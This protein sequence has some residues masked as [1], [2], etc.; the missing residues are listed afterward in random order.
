MRGRTAW[1]LLVNLSECICHVPIH[2]CEHASSGLTSALHKDRN[3]LDMSR[4]WQTGM[5]R[6]QHMNPALHDL[7]M[8][9]WCKS[10]QICADVLHGRLISDQDSHEHYGT[11]YCV[12]V[13][14]LQR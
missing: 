12:A 6:A 2:I 1:R 13:Q 10:S 14:A 8:R 9:I 4:L 3:L 5:M 11:S 7:M